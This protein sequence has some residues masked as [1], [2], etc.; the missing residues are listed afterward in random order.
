[1]H[2]CNALWL[3]SA[4]PPLPFS[5]LISLSPTS[6]LF[7][8]CL[9]PCLSPLCLLLL[10]HLSLSFIIAACE[11]WVRNYSLVF[12][13]ST[14]GLYHLRKWRPFP[15]TSF[16]VTSSPVRS[17]ASKVPSQPWWNVDVLSIKAGYILNRSQ[18]VIGNYLS[19]RL[20]LV[21][22]LV[23]TCGLGFWLP[24]LRE[25]RFRHFQVLILWSFAIAAREN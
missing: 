9:S 22:S 24:E 3:F 4:P 23:Q 25:N 19:H 12:R 1:M 20:C 15:G 10:F 13:S 8:V 16:P 7:S 14:S 2:G 6:C 21:L 11:S 18:L 5:S 17:D